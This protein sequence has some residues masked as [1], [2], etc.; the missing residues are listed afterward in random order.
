MM[1][2]ALL[3][4]AGRA[5]KTTQYIGSDVGFRQRPAEQ[6]A[7]RQI[8]A[9]ASDEGRFL[10]GLDALGGHWQAQGAPEGDDRAQYATGSRIAVNRPDE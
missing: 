10:L 6:V 9:E 8:A 4:R 3:R 7:L 1:R 2:R 5:W